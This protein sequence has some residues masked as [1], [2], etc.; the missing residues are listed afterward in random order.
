[1]RNR[2]PSAVV[3]APRAPT[4]IARGWTDVSRALA[5][6][7]GGGE[8]GGPAKPWLSDDAVWMSPYARAPAAP[9]AE[10]VPRGKSGPREL[11]VLLASHLCESGR[12]KR[13]G[14]CLDSLAALR[15]RTLV[16]WH[17]TAEHRPRVR[18]QALRQEALPARRAL[19]PGPGRG[20]VRV[21]AR[22]DG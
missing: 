20:D 22:L 8:P 12:V 10:A 6:I 16:G 15:V 21:Q 9:S 13:L 18:A 7:D 14:R 19:R 17:A 1:M 4:Q 5:H 2:K 11:S 3:S